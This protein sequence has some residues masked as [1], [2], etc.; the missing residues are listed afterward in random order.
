[1]PPAEM[2]RER[3]WVGGSNIVSLEQRERRD[4]SDSDFV[5]FYVVSDSNALRG[6][7]MLDAAGRTVRVS[8]ENA[9]YR[10]QTICRWPMNSAQVQWLPDSIIPEQAALVTAS[11]LPAQAGNAVVLSVHD[12]ARAGLDI[13]HLGPVHLE[14]ANR[15]Q[16]LLSLSPTDGRLLESYKTLKLGDAQVYTVARGFDLPRLEVFSA[17]VLG[18]EVAPGFIAYGSD[19]GVT[20]SYAKARGFFGGAWATLHNR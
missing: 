9:D 15:Q 16:V 11:P 17:R 19:Y 2:L 18:D 1:A 14:F 8:D 12:L 20:T 6:I 5:Y 10:K 3:S 4:Y 13:F 7:T